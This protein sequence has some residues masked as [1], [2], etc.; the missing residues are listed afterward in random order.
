MPT[1][2]N[3]LTPTV[4]PC[5][6]NDRW[7]TANPDVYALGADPEERNSFGLSAFHVA[8]QHGH[9]QILKYFFGSYDPQQEDHNAIYVLSPLKS[10][11]SI[12]LASVEP[13]AV[14]MILDR[15]LATTQ[16]IG[17]A[18][19]EVTSIEGKQAL[20]ERIENDGAKYT[21]IQNLLMCYGGFTPP[22][23]PKVPTKES[24]PPA[25]KVQPRSGS[26][27]PQE[28]SHHRRRGTRS[29]TTTYHT[30]QAQGSTPS[31]TMQNGAAD[32]SWRPPENGERGKT[33][34]RGRG[35]GRGHGRG[36]GR[37]RAN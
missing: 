28:G 6:F 31:E 21:E 3:G 5:A 18:W 15:G 26:P 17:N 32:P 1:W 2:S 24:S 13:E 22:P 37:G 12:A 27:G 25:N 19:T 4:S 8:V 16:D 33:R 36:R 7:T 34:G 9:V 29:K 30:T 20:L 14:W 11:L 23:T 10:L 35:R